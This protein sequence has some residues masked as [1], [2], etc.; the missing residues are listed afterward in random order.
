MRWYAVVD[1]L[2]GGWNVATVDK[3]AAEIH[4]GT[5]EAPSGEYTVACFMDEDTARH[6]ADLH[7]AQLPP[8]T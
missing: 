4:P 2:I 6:V 3:T 8:E 7:N 5:K 1:D